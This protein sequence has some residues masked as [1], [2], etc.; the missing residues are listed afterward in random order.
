MTTNFKNYCSYYQNNSCK[1]CDLIDHS[2]T[3]YQNT[4]FK[5][6]KNF[7]MPSNLFGGRN[8]AKIVVTGTYDQPIL[9]LL[10]TEVLN[11]PLHHPK[12]N[13]ILGECNQFIKSCKL[14]PYNIE[15]RTG[16]LKYLLISISHTTEE[17]MIRFVLRSKESLD[18]IKNNT[19]LLTDKFPQIKVISVNIQPKPMAIIE[20]EEEIILTQVNSIT[21]IIGG[22][23]FSY[24][25]QSFF[26]TNTEMA[27]KLF[28]LASQIVKLKKPKLIFDLYCGVGT[29]SI[30][31]APFAEK[32]IG[33][34]IS[35]DAISFA[36]NNALANKRSNIEFFADDVLLFLQKNPSFTPDFIMVNPPR[37]GLSKEIIEILLK[38]KPS[39][40]LYSSCN[41]DTL[42]R[43][44]LLLKTNYQIKSQTALD[45]FP[46]TSHL[47][48]LTELEL[49]I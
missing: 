41:Q 11:C 10:N 30:T 47:E 14:V 38:L 12:I 16:E 31:L 13:L 32:V 34:E 48:I 24:G 29:F 2:I 42:E 8:K 3:T 26:Q 18:R 49:N 20:G 6:F 23:K 36:K 15:N 46:L 21:E 19:T 39:M 17:V 43:D 27:S 28:D 7:L 25:V 22:L 35:K 37:R 5:N 40:I 4:K 33:I 44:L 45:M 1:S 9:G